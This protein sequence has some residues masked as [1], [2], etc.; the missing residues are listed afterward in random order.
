[1]HSA[2]LL[3]NVNVFDGFVFGVVWVHLAIALQPG[4]KVPAMPAHRFEI[5]E[6]CVPAV[7][8]DILG[9]EP[10]LF[11]RLQHRNEVVVL[12]DLR[13]AVLGRLIQAAVAG[14]AAEA[15]RP[16]KRRQAD[17]F[18]HGVM[19][20]APMTAHQAHLLRVGL[21]QCGVVHDQKAM[22]Q[23]HQRLD[24]LPQRRR[25]WWQSC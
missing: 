23:L 12:R 10:T 7:E 24:L 22:R 25:V 11:G 19:L 4:Q 5:G 6:A 2:P 13:L 1:M 14:Q 15:V 20:A 17:A 21:I 3:R 18:D 9:M 8:A 16:Q